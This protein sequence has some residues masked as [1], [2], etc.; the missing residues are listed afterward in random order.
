MILVRAP[1]RIALGG[2][3]TDLP[4]YYG[5]HGGFVLSAAID[6]YLYIC[7]NRPAADDLI[8]VKY[9][10]YEEVSSPHE[11]EH[12]LVRPALLELG[13]AGNIEITSMADVPA[14]TGLGSS[15]TY[16]V[17]L[18]TGLHELNRERIPTQA[19]AE[20]ACHIEMDMAGHPVGK[21]DHYLAAFGGFTCLDIARD[22]RVTVTPLDISVATTEVLHSSLLLFFTGITRG[23]STILAEQKRDTIT[24]KSDV[25][26]SLHRTKELGYRVKAALEA[27]RPDEFGAIMHE[28]WENKKRRSGLISN[29]LVDRWYEIARSSG[30]LGGKLVGA[31]GGG[32]L[33][34]Y[35]P[36][37]AKAALRAALTMEGL[38]EMPFAF[39]FEG[40]KVM[41]N[42]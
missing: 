11:V 14:G 20:E 41:L 23:A 3:G 19:L 28:H 10:R 21:Q 32:F 9:S 4:S 27:G 16:L 31:G 30:A 39:D 2:G 15:S 25:V 37:P 42:V 17:A 6:K 8:R 35:C 36:A 12:D 33:L 24:A 29:P 7:L 18:L 1:L 5:T 40:A 13:V 38:R 26:E 22:G 34:L